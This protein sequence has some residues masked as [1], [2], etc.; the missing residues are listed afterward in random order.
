MFN[1]SFNAYLEFTRECQIGNT[2]VKGKDLEII[3]VQVNA[4]EAKTKDR[5]R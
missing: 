3:W 5:D 1:I 4:L 2:N